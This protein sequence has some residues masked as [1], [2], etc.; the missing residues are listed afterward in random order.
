MKLR[1][2]LLAGVA[3]AALGLG[4]QAE[5]AY[6]FAF[7][8][9]VDGSLVITFS[10]G[11]TT[12]VPTGANAS[13]N[14]PVTQ[15]WWSDNDGNF[16]E[17]TNYIVG[18]DFGV[19][20]RNFFVFDLSN[21]SGIVTSVSL[22]LYS[23]IIEGDSAYSLWDVTTPLVDLQALDLN[24]DATIY[25]D[26][27]TGTQFGGGYALNA[28][29]SNTTL[30]FDLNATGVSAVQEALGTTFA[31]GGALS[32]ATVPEPMSLA[33]FGLGLAGLGVMARR[34]AA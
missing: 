21:V 30:T 14:T 10:G 33:L 25:E 2:L 8:G 31:I 4:R 28:G 5:A 24:P 34:K 13:N 23:H 17:N 6:A 27:G 12:T 26:L 3:C 15:G 16:Q 32:F 1:T 7:S 29:L 22:E 9:T 20:F 18:T 19:N 11:G